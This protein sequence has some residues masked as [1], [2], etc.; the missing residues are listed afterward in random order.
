MLKC[1]FEVK[2]CCIAIHVFLV[3]GNLTKTADTNV[4]IYFQ[5]HVNLLGGIVNQSIFPRTGASGTKWHGLKMTRK[6]YKGVLRFVIF[7][8]RV[9]IIWNELDETDIITTLKRHLDG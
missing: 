1:K 4:I 6:K 5:I 9:V 8:Q 2:K 7:S 3:A